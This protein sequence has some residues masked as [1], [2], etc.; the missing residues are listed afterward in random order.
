MSLERL[1]VVHHPFQGRVNTTVA[2]EI[3]GADDVYHEGWRALTIGRCV[4]VTDPVEFDQVQGRRL[5]SWE[6]RG[7]NLLGQNVHQ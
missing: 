3:D 1:V 2:S 5:S 7:R 6:G 4:H